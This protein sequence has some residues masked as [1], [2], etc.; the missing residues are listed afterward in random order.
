MLEM[1]DQP[2]Y[3]ATGRSAAFWEE[4]YGGPRVVPLPR[5]FRRRETS[6]T[7]EM[8]DG[9]SFA[10]AGLLRREGLAGG[11][12]GAATAEPAADA[13]DSADRTEDEGRT[14][15]SDSD[16]GSEDE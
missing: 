4:C 16:G 15:D 10:I 5:A 11:S 9:E 1:E 12:R 13:T 8:R 2:G 6:T 14:R 3:H 7:V